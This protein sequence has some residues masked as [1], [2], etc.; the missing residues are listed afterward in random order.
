MSLRKQIGDK[1]EAV[2]NSAIDGIDPAKIKKEL[3]EEVDK[4]V[5]EHIGGLKD[6]LK[7]LVDKI[8]G[9]QDIKPEGQ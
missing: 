3:H 5:D 1:V 4:L 6:K 8:D 9:E 2:L 7:E